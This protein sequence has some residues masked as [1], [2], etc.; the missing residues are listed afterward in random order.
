[1]NDQTDGQLLSAYAGAR[2]EA[3]F[4]EL[5]RRHLDFVYSAARRMVCDPHLA[6]DVTQGV[7]VAL[8]K[9]SA[10]LHE[11]PIL[12]G[13]LHRTAQNIAA[14]TVRTI[15]RRR[16]REQEVVAM[17]ELLSAEPDASWENIAP[18]LDSALGELAE[19]DRDAL[20]LRYFEKKSAPEMAKLLGI[21]DEA[22]QKRVSRAVE[23]LREFLAKRGVTVGGSGLVV[24][25]S[26]HAVLVAPPGLSAAI[27]STALGG[28]AAIAT[29]A[30]KAITMTA[31]QKITVAAVV[32]AAVGTGIYQATQAARL[33]T[34]L[35][36]LQ[37]QIAEQSQQAQHE[38]DEA[39]TRLATWTNENNRLQTASTELL[40]LRA[41]VTRLRATE[42]E[43]TRLRAAAPPPALPPAATP[44]AVEEL[45]KAS[46][47][48]AGFTSPQAALRTR[49][50][51]VLNGNLDRFADSV[52][53]TDATRKAFEEQMKRMAE[54]SSDPERTKLF[55][56]EALRKKYAIEE[57]LLTRLKGENIGK[58]YTGYRIL[59]QQSPSADEIVMEIETLMT[60]APARKEILKFRQFPN[61]WKVVVDADSKPSPR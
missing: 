46:W 3:A 6:E 22:A 60:S 32:A 57:G 16:A 45:P 18:H 12:S 58:E 55:L 49:G 26:T 43:L 4:A 35:Q 31:L 34:E 15:E 23:R 20:L 41:E 48:D 9:N 19:S 10:Q 42:Q 50:W 61:G 8:A 37:Q 24:M 30:A 52:F 44:A 53:I 59:S 39:A 25:I 7:F 11:R 47:F 2:S 27:L 14:Q 17:N 51:A 40:R 1:V 28:T 5:V 29:V 36:T 13:W 54:A 56:E 21:S 33:R 38:R